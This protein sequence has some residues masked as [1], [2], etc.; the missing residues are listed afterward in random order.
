MSETVLKQAMDALNEL[1]GQPAASGVKM[2]TALIQCV[3]A[4]SAEVEKQRAEIEA[5]KKSA[6]Q[7][8]PDGTVH[9]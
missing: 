7:R 1:A 4:L 2:D 3:R 8:R 5:L 9:L 6:I